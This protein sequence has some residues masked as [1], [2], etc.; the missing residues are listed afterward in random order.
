MDDDAQGA[1]LFAGRL[2][3]H[4]A[5]VRALARAAEAAGGA[6]DRQV[7]QGAVQ[8]RDPPRDVR[9]TS[10]GDDREIVSERD[11]VARCGGP[12]HSDYPSPPLDCFVAPLLAMTVEG[13]ALAPSAVIASAAKQSRGD[14][15]G[16]NGI[17]R[18]LDDELI[19]TLRTTR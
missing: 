5:L 11:G 14:T 12:D 8:R 6:C 18:A 2:S 19:K 17:R 3:E 10:E 9:R 13:G 1:E 16:L 7:R 4:Q 15:N